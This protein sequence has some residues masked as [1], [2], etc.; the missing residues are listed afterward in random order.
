VWIDDGVFDVRSQAPLSDAL[1]GEIAAWAMH[2]DS[3]FSHES[4]WR[5]PDGAARHR[6]IGTHLRNALLQELGAGYRVRVALWA[7]PD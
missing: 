3:N 4:D 2:F 6:S 7:A 1:K 5:T